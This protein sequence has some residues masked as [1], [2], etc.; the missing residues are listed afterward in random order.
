M[1][2]T[3]PV[4]PPASPAPQRIELRAA[5]VTG[6]SVSPFTLQHQVYEYPGQLWQMDVALPP[7]R[8]AQAEPWIAFLLSLNGRKGT[9]YYG[10]PTG[11][12]P[13]GAASGSPVVNGSGQSGQIISV[14]GFTPGVTG[15]MKAGDYIQ[16][17]IYL[18]RILQDAN[19]DG[20]GNASL[21]IWPRL[22]LSPAD[23]AAIITSNT[24]GV[25]RMISDE[26]PITPGGIHGFYD[27]RFSCAE[28]LS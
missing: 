21:D 19:S 13:R 16:V 7:M 1:S 17:G 4:T 23:G 9:F 10:D 5:A 26:M 11:R 8:R 14:R 28:A 27:I 2:I 15:I 22:R 6:V 12:I 24:V 20:S 18:Y 3:Y 25:W